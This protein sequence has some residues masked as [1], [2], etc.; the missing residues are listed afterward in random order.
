MT[1]P[2]DG[3]TGG[4]PDL[5]A[6]LRAA[7]RRHA[8]G[9][10]ILT[11]GA[12][13]A[14]NGMAVTAVSSFSLDPPSMLV[15]VNRSAS[16]VRDVEVGGRFGLSLLARGDE[17]LVEHFAG[18]PS[19]RERFCDPSWRLNAGELPRL[20][21]APANLGCRL[22]RTLAYGT[23]LAWIGLLEQVRLGPDAPSLVYRDG[24]LGPFG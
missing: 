24:A 4:P 15:C 22:E 23:H 19:G 12:G 3:A 1:A 21:G 8:A 14:V 11:T 17:R 2:R 20:E 13:E 18:R 7:M 9:V 16:V 5:A 6:E 10:C